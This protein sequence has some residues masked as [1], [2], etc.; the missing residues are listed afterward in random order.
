MKKPVYLLPGRGG[1]LHEGLGKALLARGL[2]VVGREMHGA[3]A[4]LGFR[5]QVATIAADLQER[6]WGSDALVIAN[7]FWAYLFLHA[8]AAMPPYIGRVL[9]LSPIVGE[10]INPQAVGFVPPY[11]RKLHELAIVGKYPSPRDCQIHVGSEDWQSAPENVK[12]LGRLLGIPV[13]VVPHNGHMLDKEY[14][15]A[16]LDEWV[17]ERIE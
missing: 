4:E 13:H 8:Q 1:R 12:E 7:S 3:F 16:V 15:S 2:D 9:L 5:Q 14:V 11:A 17:C 10:A 6:H